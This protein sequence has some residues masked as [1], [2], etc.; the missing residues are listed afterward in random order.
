[1][2]EEKAARPR[3]RLEAL[4]GFLESDEFSF[5]GLPAWINERQ[6][7]DEEEKITRRAWNS[8]APDEPIC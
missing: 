4:L 6:G 7:S 5:D 8:R 3:P 2:A 1:M